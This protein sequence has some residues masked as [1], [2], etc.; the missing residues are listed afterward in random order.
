MEQSDIKQEIQT[1]ATHG[2]KIKDPKFIQNDALETFIHT[3][4]SKDFSNT[5]KNA[6]GMIFMKNHFQGEEGQAMSKYKNAM[7]QLSEVKE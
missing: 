6:N 4:T 3:S 5:N 7:K 2:L 1:P